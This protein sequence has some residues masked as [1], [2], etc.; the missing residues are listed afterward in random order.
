MRD[1]RVVPL[2]LRPTMKIGESVENFVGFNCVASTSGSDN[3]K[4]SPL[5]PRLAVPQVQL[6]L[7]PLHLWAES[8]RLRQPLRFNSLNAF[9]VPVTPHAGCIISLARRIA[10]W[11]S[12]FPNQPLPLFQTR[13]DCLSRRLVKSRRLALDRLP[14]QGSPAHQRIARLKSRFL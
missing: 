4:I 7:V 5:L 9:C 6:H 3:K 1:S 11:Q 2:R 10:M 8:G 12:V 14:T 13:A